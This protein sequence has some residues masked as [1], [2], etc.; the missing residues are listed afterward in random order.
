MREGTPLVTFK[1]F[2][3]LRVSS[4]SLPPS[5]TCSLEF[6]VEGVG[7]AVC[8]CVGGG[9]LFCKM[10]AGCVAQSHYVSLPALQGETPHT[11]SSLERELVSITM[12]KYSREARWSLV[13]SNGTRE[14]LRRSNESREEIKANCVKS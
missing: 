5:R 7:Q 10:V 6:A 11:P 2:P 9:S 13:L 8:L 14:A 4:A 1:R 12:T 3:F